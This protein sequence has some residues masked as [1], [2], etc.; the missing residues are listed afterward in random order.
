MPPTESAADIELASLDVHMRALFPSP[1]AR[2]RGRFRTG[3][4]MDGA[5]P[6]PFCAANALIAT[7]RT[8]IFRSLGRRGQEPESP[9]HRRPLRMV[10][11]VSLILV[12]ATGAMVVAASPGRGEIAEGRRLYD[13][14]CAICHG[15]DLEGQ[16][17]WQTRTA[18]GRLPAPPHD[19]TGHTWHHPDQDLLVIVRDGLAA[20]AP[21]YESAMPAFGGV[22]TDGQITAILAFIKSTWPARE[23]EYQAARTAA[24]VLR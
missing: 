24:W 23:R 19:A 2:P 10:A 3:R 4:G 5:S 15:A 20:I 18:D 22:L 9:R 7:M 6:Y 13:L 16:P 8:V 14:Q 17:N 11:A 21:G 12:A 1:S